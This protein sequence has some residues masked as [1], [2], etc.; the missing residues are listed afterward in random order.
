MKTFLIALVLTITANCLF[1][2]E[3]TYKTV[4]AQV[5][6]VPYRAIYKTSDLSISI[7]SR[8]GKISLIRQSDYGL[9]SFKF[10]DFNDDGYQDL[11]IEYMSNVPGVCELA[12]YD[13]RAKKFVLVDNFSEYPD[14]QKLRGTFL[15]Y[16]Y[17]RSGCADSDWDSDLFKIINNKVVKIG[18]ISGRGC[19]EEPGIFI[20]KTE[21]REK[22]IIKKYPI[23]VIEKYKNYKWG[24]IKQYWERNCQKFI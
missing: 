3:D 21:G 22:I 17:R 15:Y 7:V 2:Q 23:D 10:I 5:D 24:F 6:G 8:D 20:S 14:P 1:A 16:S 19:D 9:S 4:K 13:K 11:L 18:N 12:L